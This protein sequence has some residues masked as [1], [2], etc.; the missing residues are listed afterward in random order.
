MANDLIPAHAGMNRMVWD[1]RCDD[2]TQIP[3]AFY[4]NEAPRGPIVAPGRYQIRLR[5]GG[6]TRTAELIV[7][8]DPRVANSDAGIAEKTELA[9]ATSRDIDALHRAVNDIRAERTKFKASTSR[10]RPRRQTAGHRTG[11][12]AG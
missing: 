6:A 3:G 7:V 11:P 1:L 9:L 4:E 12:Y 8:A 5:L 10:A 2:P